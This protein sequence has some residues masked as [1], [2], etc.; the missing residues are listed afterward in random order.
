MFQ[1]ES[2][3]VTP[4]LKILQW[5]SS[6]RIKSKVTINGLLGPPYSLV[7]C[8]LYFSPFLSSSFARFTLAFWW[9]PN[10]PGTFLPLGLCAGCSLDL[11]HTSSRFLQGL[12]PHLLQVSAS[13]SVSNKTDFDHHIIS[14]NLSLRHQPRQHW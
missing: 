11:E 8:S 2:G 7:P 3:H 1:K 10:L 9:F 4:L 5:K 14:H 6:N 13:M 12:L